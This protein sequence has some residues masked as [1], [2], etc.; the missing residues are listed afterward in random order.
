M[1]STGSCKAQ[2]DYGWEERDRAGAQSQKHH[3]LSI[4]CKST[5]DSL[6]CCAFFQ[7]ESGCGDIFEAQHCGQLGPEFGVEAGEILH[8]CVTS[9]S[10]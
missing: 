7:T 3:T 1:L 4:C 9:V 2:S 10:A 6:P 8:W 5:F